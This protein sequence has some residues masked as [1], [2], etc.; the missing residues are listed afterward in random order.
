MRSIWKFLVNWASEA[1]VTILTILSVAGAAEMIYLLTGRAPKEDVI[2]LLDYSSRCVAV[3]L[4][5]T[6]TSVATQAFG[7]WYPAE[8]ILDRPG[9][10]AI[11][12]TKTVVIFVACLYALTH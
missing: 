1:S 7:H 3:A 11:Q 8:Q 2:W 9:L 12:A 5:I 4:A 10:A 6:F